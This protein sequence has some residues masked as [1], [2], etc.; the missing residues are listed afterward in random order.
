MLADDTQ[1]SCPEDQIGVSTSLL[2]QPTMIQ[3]IDF[4]GV[5]DHGSPCRTYSERSVVRL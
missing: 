4:M 3:F 2:Y 5:R 1:Q